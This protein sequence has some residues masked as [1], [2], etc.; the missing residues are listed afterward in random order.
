MT[1]VAAI[2]SY[3]SAS[4]SP[5]KRSESIARYAPTAHERTR[6]PKMIT[7]SGAYAC[8]GVYVAMYGEAS[9]PMIIVVVVVMIVVPLLL[10]LSVLLA[11]RLDAH[12]PTI[13]SVR[14]AGRHE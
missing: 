9:V 5:S 8:L 7:V 4:S 3:R 13:S 12:V 10:V 1:R 6:R 11:S 2:V 14:K